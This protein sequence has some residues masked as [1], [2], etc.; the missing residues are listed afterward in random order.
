MFSTT[1]PYLHSP[2]NYDVF[3]CV[4]VCVTLDIVMCVSDIVMCVS[5]VPQLHRRLR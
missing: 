5:A 1:P 4:F 2:V 3:I